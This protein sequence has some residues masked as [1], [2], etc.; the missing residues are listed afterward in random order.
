MIPE[1]LEGNMS[2]SGEIA[3]VS[4]VLGGTPVR[5]MVHGQVLPE[6]DSASKTAGKTE[7]DPEVPT[8]SHGEITSGDLNVSGLRPRIGHLD[9]TET[10][11][12]L[13][14]ELS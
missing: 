1:E 12:H 5:S 13:F 9:S 7:N 8:E 3:P 6:S 14:V 4:G 10:W 11:G 2:Q